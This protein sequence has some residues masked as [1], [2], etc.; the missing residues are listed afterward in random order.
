MNLPHLSSRTIAVSVATL[1]FAAVAWPAPASAQEWPARPVKIVVPNGPGG[2]TDIVSRI[3]AQELSTTLGQS[4]VVE[5]KPGAGTTIG[6]DSVAKTDPDGYTML[7]MSNA[8]AVSGAGHP[9]LRYEP[10][11]DF[12]MVSMV[13]TTPLVLVIA[14]GSPRGAPLLKS[15]KNTSLRKSPSGKA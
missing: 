6:A 8:H 5:N 13:G 7:M 2:G 1:A 3:L 10:V 14:P 4:F 11:K 12:R 15:W 9:K